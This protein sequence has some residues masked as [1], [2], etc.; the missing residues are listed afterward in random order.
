MIWI[1]CTWDIQEFHH[2]LK[3][4]QWAIAR[5]TELQVIRTSDS[6]QDEL[7][8]SSELLLFAERLETFVRGLV[9]KQ[10]EPASHA[11]VLMISPDG[12]VKK[13][14]ALP[15]QLLPYRSLKD[16]SMRLL[17][18]QLKLEM[19]NHNMEVVGMINLRNYLIV[20][21]YVSNKVL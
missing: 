3:E 7:S 17:S 13:P 2:L 21:L 14:Y 5:A 12:R 9:R 20:S 6:R 4:C 10:R 18:N 11:M 1:A 16:C 15:V 19:K 8:F